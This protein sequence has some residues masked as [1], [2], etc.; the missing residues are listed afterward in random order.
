MRPALKSGV[1][2]QDQQPHDLNQSSEGKR[3]KPVLKSGRKKRKKENSPTGFNAN[4]SN[5]MLGTDLGETVVEYEM[6]DETTW[7]LA[8]NTRVVA[9]TEDCHG[10]IMNS[11]AGFNANQSNY[12]LGTALNETVVGNEMVDTGLDQ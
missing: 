8:F 6:V 5:E 1:Q 7:V 12:W 10:G 3:D 2:P 11:P 9:N 4:Q